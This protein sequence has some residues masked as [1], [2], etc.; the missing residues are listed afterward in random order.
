MLIT[1]I[2]SVQKR[3]QFD[4]VFSGNKTFSQSTST[5]IYSTV[6]LYVPLTINFDL[7]TYSI[8]FKSIFLLTYNNTFRS[9]LTTHLG[10]QLGR[11]RAMRPA[12]QVIEWSSS[13]F[14][15]ISLKNLTNS[16]IFVRSKSFLI[17]F[18]TAH[19]KQ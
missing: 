13:L 5:S 2:V 1:K 17:S 16:F 19:S 10:R 8:L 15:N 14:D 7:I 9:T 18:H 11:S 4:K 3:P 6:K 12:I